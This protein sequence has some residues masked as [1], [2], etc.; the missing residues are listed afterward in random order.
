MAELLRLWEAENCSLVW[1]APTL[2]VHSHLRFIRRKVLRELFSQLN[3][4]KKLV[5]SLLLN[6]S[7]HAK[8]YQIHKSHF[9]GLKK[10][11]DFSSISF[12]IFPFFFFNVLF[13][14]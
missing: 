9:S 3:C 13:F 11:P 10:F 7:V 8:V 5:H 2:M 14:N 1:A 12:S 6:F 4:K